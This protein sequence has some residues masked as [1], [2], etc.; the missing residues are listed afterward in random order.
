MDPE[1][2]SS[3]TLRWTRFRAY[4]SEV[5][6]SFDCLMQLSVEDYS[7]HDAAACVNADHEPGLLSWME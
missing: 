4:A 6:R 1:F 7:V 2:V 3:G 5:E